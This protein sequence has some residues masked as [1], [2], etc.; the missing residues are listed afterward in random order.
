ML[1]GLGFCTLRR[2]ALGALL[3]GIGASVFLLPA[4]AASAP[5]ET[6]LAAN[7]RMDRDSQ[8]S[9]SAETSSDQCQPAGAPGIDAGKSP[10]QSALASLQYM[11]RTGAAPPLQQVGFSKWPA[12]PSAQGG[13]QL[14][15]GTCPSGYG[16]CPNGRCCPSGTLCSNDGYCVQPGRNYCGGGRSCPAGENCTRDG[17]CVRPG[18]VYCGGGRTCPGGTSCTNDGKCVDPNKPTCPPG[19]GLCNNGR[20]C[21]IGTTCTNDG[22]CVQAGR[23]YCGG[24]LSCPAG[25]LCT[26]QGTCTT[27]GSG[28]A[29]GP[30]GGR[31]DPAPPV[32]LRRCIAVSYENLAGA[33]KD[34]KFKN[35]CEVGLD[36]VYSSCDPPSFGGK[37]TESRSYLSPGSESFSLSGYGAPPEIVRVCYKGRCE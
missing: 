7:F 33:Y 32:N 37:C 9:S 3:I 1:F 27:P 5:L 24:G 16:M 12:A 36:Y 23:V 21:P 11:L 28:A 19:Q 14:A 25:T 6:I 26:G 20:C 35:V 8:D 10:E 31:N 2:I 29:P 4:P 15:Q 30:S 13:V 34:R 22:Y 18:L 17:Y